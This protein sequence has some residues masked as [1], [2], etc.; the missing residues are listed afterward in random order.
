VIDIRPHSAWITRSSSERCESIEAR[1]QALD[2]RG[3]LAA[4]SVT[5]LLETLHGAGLAKSAISSRPR[6]TPLPA[7]HTGVRTFDSR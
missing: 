4:S 3:S 1:D 2:E 6:R 7:I 5:T